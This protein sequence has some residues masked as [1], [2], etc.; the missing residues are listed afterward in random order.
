M[1]ER[2][3]IWIIHLVWIDHPFEKSQGTGLFCKH[4]P[5]VSLK[6]R[7]FITSLLKIAYHISI[8]R[9]I[10]L[11]VFKNERLF[12]KFSISMLC[13]DISSDRPS[14]VKTRCTQGECMVCKQLYCAHMYT[15]SIWLYTDR[16]TAVSSGK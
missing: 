7:E 14:H 6:Y 2:L 15:W 12:P 8:F 10:E 4:L 5:Q 11:L 3:I 13:S 16:R 1:C 9:E